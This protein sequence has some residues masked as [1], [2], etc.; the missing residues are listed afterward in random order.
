MVTNWSSLINSTG[1]MREQS[2]RESNGTK[3]RETMQINCEIAADNPQPKLKR[4]KSVDTARINAVTKETN[5]RIAHDI[6]R[7][8]F[9]PRLVKP[10]GSALYCCQVRK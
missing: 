8:A 2:R 9:G 10:D 7:S 6:I 3:H 1:S 5:K 4:G